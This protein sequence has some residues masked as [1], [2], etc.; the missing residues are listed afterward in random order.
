ML[1]NLR[2]HFEQGKIKIP[3]KFKEAYWQ[4][5]RYRYQE[6]TDKPVKKDDHTPDSTMCALQHFV[7][8]KF[9]APFPS[10]QATDR[11]NSDTPITAGL[12]DKKF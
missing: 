1:G 11:N 10:S 4:Y 12:L 5:K 2:A 9:A 3:K 6:N 7:L 8:G